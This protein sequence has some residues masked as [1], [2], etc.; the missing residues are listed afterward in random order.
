VVQAL[1]QELPQLKTFTTLSPIPTFKPWL[2]Q[3]ITEC[4]GKT[5][6]KQLKK[7]AK[8]IQTPVTAE[9]LLPALEGTAPAHSDVAQWLAQCAAQYLCKSVVNGLPL[10]P[11]ARFHLGNGAMV[12][13]INLGADTWANGMR[14]SYGLMVNY[15]VVPAKLSLPTQPRV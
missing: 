11:V 2:Q 12:A 6:D 10:D 9:A 8:A 14:Q 7:L 1:Q 5:S 15:L 3:N 13:R 4:L